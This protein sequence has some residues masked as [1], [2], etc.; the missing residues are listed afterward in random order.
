VPASVNRAYLT[1]LWTT[2][3]LVASSIFV[4]AFTSALVAFDRWPGTTPGAQIDH[5][6]VTSPA[7]T[8][9]RVIAGP[10]AAARPAKGAA[11]AGAHRRTRTAPTPVR[12]APAAP[13]ARHPTA[14]DPSAS[15][16][17]TP[18]APTTPAAPPTKHTSPTQRSSPLGDVLRQSGGT[19]GSQAQ[20]VS[21][22]GSTLVETSADSG[23]GAVDSTYGA[24]PPPTF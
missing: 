20:P 15:T 1:S 18:G 8:V 17:S 7:A 11:A 16:T 10:H 22:D 13:P 19:I 2:G 4:L 5:V 9:Q 6:T 14:T 23:G 12:P 3:I 24:V 21:P